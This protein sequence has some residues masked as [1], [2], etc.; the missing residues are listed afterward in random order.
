[1]A[2]ACLKADGIGYAS[3][4]VGRYVFQGLDL[5]SAGTLALVR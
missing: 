4:E 1:M 5:L 2:G 3:G